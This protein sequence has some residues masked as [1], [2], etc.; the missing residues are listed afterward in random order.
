LHFDYLPINL[1]YCALL[2]ASH[3]RGPT[4]QSL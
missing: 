2:S 4:H 3:E 1:Q